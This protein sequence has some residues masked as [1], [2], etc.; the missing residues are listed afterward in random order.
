MEKGE[1]P[2]KTCTKPGAGREIKFNYR[3]IGDLLSN[4][5][6]TNPVFVSRIS[7]SR[8]APKIAFSSGVNGDSLPNPIKRKTMGSLGFRL[9][10]FAILALVLLTVRVFLC[11]TRATQ[12][13]YQRKRVRVFAFR[14]RFAII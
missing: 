9:S 4:P 6:S 5:I 2:Y 11:W 8:S 13:H 12:V 3:L 7:R 14:G 1:K 10:S